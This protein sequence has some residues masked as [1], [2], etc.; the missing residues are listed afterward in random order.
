[1]RLDELVQTLTGQRHTYT[2]N[3]VTS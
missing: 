1:M 2:Q 3:T